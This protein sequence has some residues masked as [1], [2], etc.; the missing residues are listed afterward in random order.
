MSDL[1][2]CVF[3]CDGTLVDSQHT[4]IR[5]MTETACHYYLP[6]PARENVRAV[7]GLSLE[8]AMM[9]VFQLTEWEEAS[10]FAETYK[11]IFRTY[12]AD[13]TVQEPLYDG[14]EKLL[15]DLS[16]AGWLL[17][18]ATGKAWRGLEAT[19]SGH[20]LM[21]HFVTF[22]TADRAMGK[23][24][25]DML[26]RAMAECGVAAKATVMIG[27]TTF[28]MEMSENAGTLALGVDWGYHETHDLLAA[29][30]ETVVSTTDQISAFLEERFSG[31]DRF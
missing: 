16:N 21:E 11:R 27:D 30:A 24:H 23:P 19:L 31:E 18:V 8:E 7:I 29:G 2:L 9:Q 3:D 14:I 10:A 26:E 20:G 28:D 15:S 25:P 1:K 5:C 12:R 6:K 13:E 22:Q 17:G 4:I